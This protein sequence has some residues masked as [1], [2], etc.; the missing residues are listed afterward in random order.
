M[1]IML[2]IDPMSCC[3]RQAY[4]CTSI[5]YTFTIGKLI[6][7]VDIIIATVIL[8][9]ISN[10]TTPTFIFHWVLI[11]ENYSLSN[12]IIQMSILS[13]EYDSYMEKI[14]AINPKALGAEAIC[15]ET[16]GFYMVKFYFY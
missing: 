1:F 10:I 6:W 2:K 9:C 8:I 14:K 11:L 4:L 5:L 3:E 16:L 15:R 13:E 7:L 12:L